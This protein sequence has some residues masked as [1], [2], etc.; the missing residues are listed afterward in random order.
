[1]DEQQNIIIYRTADGKASNAHG[2]GS[3]VHSGGKLATAL[4][5]GAHGV[6]LCT[7]CAL[8]TGAL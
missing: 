4:S 5:S 8:N 1:M 2:V 3:G 7:R 6:Q